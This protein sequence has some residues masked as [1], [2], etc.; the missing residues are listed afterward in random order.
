VV[1]GLSFDSIDEAKARWLERDFEEREVWEVVKAM[2]GDKVSGP[3]ELYSILPSLLDCF[4][5][6]HHEGLL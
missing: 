5:R 3:N 1:D 4:E 6:K 2:N